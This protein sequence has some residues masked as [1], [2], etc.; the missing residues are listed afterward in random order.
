[1]KKFIVFEGLDGSKGKTTQVKLLASSLKKIKK[2][3]LLTREP[4]H[5][6]F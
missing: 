2:D 5:K 4:G 1:M 6:Y 3:F